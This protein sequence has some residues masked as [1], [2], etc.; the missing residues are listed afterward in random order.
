[1]PFATLS[2]TQVAQRILEYE[3]PKKKAW[4]QS[5]WLQRMLIVWNCAWIVISILP[6]PLLFDS[7]PSLRPA[8]LGLYCLLIP[9][10]TVLGV[11]PSMILVNCAYE[12]SH[13]RRRMRVL[14]MLPLMICVIC[15]GL[16]TW[17]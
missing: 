7:D 5:L 14:T 6:L 17:I 8:A 10:T 15:V 9:A 3:N 1:M 16:L 4:A 2:E 11:I 12:P 13:T